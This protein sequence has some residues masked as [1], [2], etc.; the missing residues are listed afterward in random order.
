LKCVLAFLEPCLKVEAL[1]AFRIMLILVI[2][3][4]L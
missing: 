1:K 2:L 4:M 3:V